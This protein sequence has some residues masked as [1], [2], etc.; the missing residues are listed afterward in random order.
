MSERTWNTRSQKVLGE[1]HSSLLAVV[2]EAK[3]YSDVDFQLVDGA[4][5][6]AEQRDLFKK[7][8]SKVN[9]DAYNPKELAKAAKHVVNE[10]EPLARAVDIVVSVP[11]K[12]SL[13]YDRSHLCYIAGVVMSQ[14]KCMGIKMRWG[15]NWDRDGEII[16][17]Q[18]FQDLVHFELD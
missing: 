14:A 7:G 1:L 13:G 12:G 3:K 5:T 17:D 10:V 6:V 4:R 9:P 11:G 2:Q 8:S 16:T 15:G 18:T